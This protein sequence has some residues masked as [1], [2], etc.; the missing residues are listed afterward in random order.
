MSPLANKNGAFYSRGRGDARACS[1]VQATRRGRDAPRHPERRTRSVRSR[2]TP[3]V[4][5][6][7]SGGGDSG[8]GAPHAPRPGCDPRRRQQ[9]QPAGSFDFAPPPRRF[10]Q[11]DK[12]ATAF[13]GAPLRMTGRRTPAAA[14]IPSWSP[15]ALQPGCGPT[16][17]GRARPG[18]SFDCAPLPRRS[19]QDDKRATAFCGA[20]LRTTRSRTPAAAAAIPGRSP[21]CP[22]ARMWPHRR[23]ARATREVLRLRAADGGA[24]LRM[25]KKAPPSAALRSG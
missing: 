18:R 20:P 1:V 24:S 14:A 15:H 9:P 10:A 6:A 25:T 21:A 8:L 13:R 23:R 17:A 4:A 16:A 11:D 22:L 12:G 3:L 19:A 5:N 2:R 7:R